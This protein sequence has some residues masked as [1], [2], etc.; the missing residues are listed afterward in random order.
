MDITLTLSPITPL[1]VQ[2]DTPSP[3]PPI[4]GHPIP[5]NLEAH[6]DS[7][8]VKDT[9]ARDRAVINENKGKGVNAVKA[10]ACWGNPQ[11]KEYKEKGVIDSGCSRHMT[12]NKCYLT[13]Y[14]DYDGG[15]VSFRDVLLGLVYTA[16]IS[17]EPKLQLLSKFLALEA[18]FEGRTTEISQSSG[19][20]NLVAYE[21]IYKEWED[22]MERAATT[23]SNLD[24]EQDSD[25]Q[26]R[27]ETT[28]KKSNDPPLSR[29]YTLGSGEDSMKLLEL[30][31]LCTKLSDLVSKKKR[32]MLFLPNTEIF[33]QLALI[34]VPI[35]PYDSPLPGGHTPRSDEGRM[36]HTE[37]M[38]LVIKLSHKVLALET[39]LQ[40]T[41]KVLIITNVTK[42][43]HEEPNHPKIVRSS[44]CRPKILTNVDEFK[45]IV[46]EKNS[47]DGASMPVSTAGLVQEITSSSRASK[48]KGKAVIIESEPEETALNTSSSSGFFTEDER[49]NIRARV[50]VDEEL[51]QK[52]QVEEMGKYSEVDQAK[53]LVDL[54]NQRKRV[55]PQ[56]RAEAKRNKPMTQAQQRTYML[57]YIKNQEGGYSIKQ[58]KSLSFEEVKE[59]FETTMRRVY[60]FVPIDSELEVQRL[61]RASQE[62]LEESAKR[63]KIGKASGSGE[64]QSAEKEKEV[65][66]KE[67]HKLLVI[68]PV[69][70]QF[71]Y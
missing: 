39:D 52:L 62:V 17:L 61:K 18:L 29:G 28:F 10:L 8:L 66:E 54:I 40:Q 57:N 43:Y 30:M 13:E 34:R 58:L 2:F 4:F 68:V 26:T 42:L 20:I 55:F 23:A 9:T 44:E 5:W 46:E 22:R 70:D 31:E 19:P 67:L 11:Q 56:Q 32:E 12:G 27:F 63:Q 1:D 15:F 64:E 69:E 49:E 71:Y 6:G 45:L 38:D 51:T 3:S 35:P 41:K 47:T 24:A 25:A 60:S 53:M 48:D 36:Q 65:L 59:I 33:K 50:E 21:T 7:Y 16:G 14:E 37:L